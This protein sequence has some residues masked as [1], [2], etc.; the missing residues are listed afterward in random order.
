MVEENELDRMTE[1]PNKG[2]EGT[3][4]YAWYVVGVLMLVY[5]FSFLDRSILSM[6]VSDLKSGLDLD[7]DWQ[8][9]F[10]MGP[11]FAIFYTIFGIPFGRLADTRSRKHIVSLGLTIWSL[12]TVGCGLAQHFW[13]M[14]LLRVGVGVGEASLS[15]SAYSII[16]D[17]F[18]PAKL[19][20]AIAIYSSGIY[21]G[22]GLAYMIGGRAV[23]ALRGTEPW[24]LP[25]L[26]AIEGW[27]KVFFIIGLPGLLVVP[28]VLLTIQEPKRKGVIASKTGGKG[29]AIPFSEV[30]SYVRENRRAL[31]MHNVGF[32][33]LSFSSYGSAA[34]LPEMFKRVHGWDAATFGLIY[35]LVVFIGSASG[36]ISGGIFADAL[37]KRGYRDAK[38][39]VGWI[40]AWA[41][42]P[43]GVAFPIIGD[44]AVA[45]A[46]VIPAAFLASMP[47]GVAPAALQEM[48]PNNL[49]GQISAI[50]LFVIN[51]IGLAIGPMLL[52]LCTDFVFTEESYGLGGIRWSLL[53]TT[54]AAH[55]LS[56]FL[57]WRGMKEFRMALDR[58]ESLQKG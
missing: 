32:A 41:W 36:A 26:G 38:I 1:D 39:R 13:Q 43:F 31:A 9:G 58:K 2:T 46:V 15:P 49:R 19:A 54:L 42:I 34:W 45:M 47:F 12:M 4:A 23:S 11:A 5:V 57:L 55:L 44:G 14:A 21:L 40:A 6:M 50:Y 29:T 7:Q 18:P 24:Q 48:V 56:T 37:L 27:Q 35:G 51:L 22:S 28:I 16:S 52:A 3:E 30:M 17:K 8:V 33:L 25:L 53:S 10:L 20:R